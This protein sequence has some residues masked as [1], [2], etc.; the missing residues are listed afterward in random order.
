MSTFRR[1]PGWLILISLNLL[2]F[3]AIEL[4]SSQIVRLYLAKDH[5]RF[6]RRSV[7]ENPFDLPRGW[8]ML[9]NAVVGSGRTRIQTGPYGEPIVPDP[10]PNPDYTIA[11]LGGS[12]VFG[13]GVSNNAWTLPAQIQAALRSTPVRMLKCDYCRTHV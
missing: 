2:I 11:V 12:T 7:V 1:L 3:A 4:V 13:I 5:A 10:L 9:S 6:L 8:S